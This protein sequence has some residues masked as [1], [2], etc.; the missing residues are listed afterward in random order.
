MSV[1]GYL[2]VR[3]FGDDP[4][5]DLSCCSGLRRKTVYNTGIFLDMDGKSSSH[6]VN[7][8]NP[9][10]LSKHSVIGWFWRGELLEPLC[11]AVLCISWLILKVAHSTSFGNQTISE[12]QNSKNLRMR[13]GKKT[14][15][16]RIS[17]SEF[18]ESLSVGGK[19]DRG[20]PEPL[21]G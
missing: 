8:R 14:G 2:H 3:F 6:N 17:H 7:F 9:P 5:L 18:T 12:I 1:F 16:L 20:A 15:E 19:R 13:Q 4:H 11:K 10:I 21:L